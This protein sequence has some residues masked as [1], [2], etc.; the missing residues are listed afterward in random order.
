MV[1]CPRFDLGILWGVFP[2]ALD[3]MGRVPVP[4]LS[5]G[6]AL[7]AKFNYTFDF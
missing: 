7:Y 3:R 2:E 1:L 5:S 6:R 4:P